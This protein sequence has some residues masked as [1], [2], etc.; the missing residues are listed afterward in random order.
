MLQKQF[1]ISE[2]DQKYVIKLSGDVE[3]HLK[4]NARDRNAGTLGYGASRETQR[5]AH[6]P[7][8]VLAIWRNE[9]G[10]DQ[11]NPDHTEA[12][13][14]LVD[15]NEWLRTDGGGDKHSANS[16]RIYSGAA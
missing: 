7:P 4:Q 12:I 5:V 13:L 6:I 3:P 8:I 9:Y 16:R 11:F 1:K 2:A 15:E 14:Q 10:V